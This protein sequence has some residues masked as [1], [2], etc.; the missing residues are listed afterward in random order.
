M[1][2]LY[3]EG[4]FVYFERLMGYDKDM[5]KSV[6]TILIVLLIIVAGY[7]ILTKTLVNTPEIVV[8]EVA[9]RSKCE[10]KPKLSVA[11]VVTIAQK[12]SLSKQTDGWWTVEFTTGATWSNNPFTD[13]CIWA[14]RSNAPALEGSDIVSYSLDI[15]FVQDSTGEFRYLK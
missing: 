14:V 7:F 1:L 4:I 10:F 2:P 13:Q 12:T 15:T 8:P 11:E 5:K 6:R 9:A 3:N